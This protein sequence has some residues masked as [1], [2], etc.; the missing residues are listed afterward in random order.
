VGSLVPKLSSFLRNGRYDAFFR[1]DE[2]VLLNRA[3]GCRAV[4]N[5]R[6]ECRADGYDLREKL[7]RP[8]AAYQPSRIACMR[9]NGVSPLRLACQTQNDS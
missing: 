7:R 8:V 2:R 3:S 4:L 6:T 9:K 1:T 5:H